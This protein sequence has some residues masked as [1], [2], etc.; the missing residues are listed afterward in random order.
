M[1]NGSGGSFKGALSRYLGGLRALAL[2]AILPLLAMHSQPARALD[3][4]ADDYAS[5]AIP[6]GTNLAAASTCAQEHHTSSAA[7]R[8]STA[9][10]TTIAHGPPTPSLASGGASHLA[11]TS[12]RCMDA[13]CPCA[14]D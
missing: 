13:T 4:D 5:G 12:R 2:A 10:P 11:G 7:R 9:L 14:T 6:A 3:L 8:P 1:K